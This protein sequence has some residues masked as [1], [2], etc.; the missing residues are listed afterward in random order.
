MVRTSMVFA[1]LGS[2]LLLDPATGS[3]PLEQSAV[4]EVVVIPTL[5]TNHQFDLDYSVAHVEALLD[6]VRP[7]AIVLDDFTD[8]LRNGCVVSATAP[9]YHVA[10][11]YAQRH[12][13]PIW[14]THARPPASAY[15]QVV[16]AAAQVNGQTP[17]AVERNYRA[18]LET[19]TARIAR[20][21]SFAP[22]PETLAFLLH[23]GFARWAASRTPAQ[24]ETI[25]A[26]G[27]Q[28]ADTLLSIIAANQQPKRW[29]VV[30][31]W[32]PAL[33]TAEALRLKSAV[34]YRSITGF[35]R[36]ADRALANHMNAGNLAWILSGTLDEWYGMWAPQVFPT[37]R[38]AGLLRQLQQLAPADPTTRFLQARWLMQ[39][40]DYTA[41]EPLL[42]SLV[43]DSLDA[44]LPFPINGKWVR[45]PWSQ[46]RQKAILNLAFV[47]D[48]R[49]S[50]DSALAL[51]R[52][53]LAKGTELDAEARAAGW[54][55]DDI[56][57]VIESY[58]QSPYT[59]LPT[60]AF[61]H[62]RLVAAIPSCD[63]AGAR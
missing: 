45:P 58:T 21:F 18:R 40:R 44:R 26:N 33:A 19:E 50:R 2:L 34:R 10:L 27:R 13:V 54:V 20:E 22:Q 62:Y 53:L 47:R 3:L 14:G 38:L 29:V 12:N 6:A 35:F 63:P 15:Q 57:S 30:M 39:N 8:W 42:V 24:R 48:L 16:R 52:E 56:R 43:D 7:D 25:A 1:L 46:V 61:R 28:A 17:E 31:P 59:A 4:P 11:R 41:A 5:G 49:G 51:Y 32:G 55:Y 23:T 60:E 9:E 36:A 37:E